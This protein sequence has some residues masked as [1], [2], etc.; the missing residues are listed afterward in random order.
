M[1]KRFPTHCNDKTCASCVRAGDFIFVSHLGGGYVNTN[2]AFQIKK[3]FESLEEVLAQ[4]NAKVKDVIQINLYLKDIRDL[5][6]AC[7]VFSEI[8][9]EEPPARMTTTTDF[10]DENCLCMIDVVAYNI[11]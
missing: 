2:V 9:G 7:D 8:F 10:Y 6:E 1:I 4:A 11:N 5:R 3:I